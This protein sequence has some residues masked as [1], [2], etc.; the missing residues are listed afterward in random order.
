MMENGEELGNGKRE[1]VDGQAGGEGDNW[2]K[3]EQE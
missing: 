2:G 1:I 3:D